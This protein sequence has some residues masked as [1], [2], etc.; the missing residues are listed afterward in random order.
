MA[1]R[2]Y[3][4][5]ATN[6]TTGLPTAEQ[7]SLTATV[8]VDAQ[9]TNRSMNTTIGTGMVNLSLSTSTTSSR[10]LYYTR[11]VSPPI[12]QTSVAANTWTY[13]FSAS[14]A[15]TATNFP[16]NGLDKVVRVNCYVWRP[17]TSAK[18]GTILDGNTA[19]TVD[20]GTAGQNRSHHVTFTGARSCKYSE[21]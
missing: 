15:S 1:T 8:V 19:A 5:N 21:Q 16:C 7:S 17:S 13:N 12:F 18:I 14:E 2:L 11:F 3:F 6:S 20:E 9:T 10:N 4:H